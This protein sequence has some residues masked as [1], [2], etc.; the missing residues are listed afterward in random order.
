MRAG[1]ELAVVQM[2][3]QAF[4][5]AVIEPQPGPALGTRPADLLG[6]AF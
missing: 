4:L 3:P 6:V 1:E 2:P 5:G